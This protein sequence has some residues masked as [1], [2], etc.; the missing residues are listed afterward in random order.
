M[1][2]KVSGTG[3]EPGGHYGAWMGSPTS[4]RERTAFSAM[5][6][7]LLTLK[8]KLEPGPPHTGP[9]MAP[10]PTRHWREGLKSQ[11]PA[12]IQVT[13]PWAQVL[14]T[15]RGSASWRHTFQ[16]TDNHSGGQE[17]T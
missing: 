5:Q 1:Q 7:A 12:S 8:R 6:G 17:V 3:N 4:G 9:K 11:F 15:L 2:D 16:I 10:K 13:E 14:C